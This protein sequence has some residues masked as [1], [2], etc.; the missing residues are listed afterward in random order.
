LNGKGLV[1][2]LINCLKIPPFSTIVSPVFFKVETKSGFD[3]TLR[4]KDNSYEGMFQR[5]GTTKTDNVA[6][7]K[8]NFYLS[9]INEAQKK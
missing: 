4:S 2:I 3:R 5:K 6:N 1:P 7:K 8:N 9:P